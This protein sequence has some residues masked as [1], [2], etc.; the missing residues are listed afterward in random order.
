MDLQYS[1]AKN[2]TKITVQ[3]GTAHL[4]CKTALQIALRRRLSK[5]CYQN[6]KVKIV[7]VNAALISPGKKDTF[8][9]IIMF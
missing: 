5:L 4:H 1:V 8:I 9:Q 2:T 3:K 6:R 7:H